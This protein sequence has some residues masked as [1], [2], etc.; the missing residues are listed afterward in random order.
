MPTEDTDRLS[1]LQGPYF[2]RVVCAGRGE[3]FTIGAKGHRRHLRSVTVKSPS[4][5]AVLDIPQLHRTILSGRGEQRP[6]GAKSH[7]DG[8]GRMAGQRVQQRAVWHRPQLH[9]LHRTEV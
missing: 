7:G 8:P 6:V 1:A 2:H 4:Q 5:R 9:A 3:E